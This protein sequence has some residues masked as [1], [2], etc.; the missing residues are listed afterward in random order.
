LVEYF[1]LLVKHVHPDII[2]HPIS[3]KTSFSDS[4]LHTTIKNCLSKKATFFDPEKGSCFLQFL[5]GGFIEE[6]KCTVLDYVYTRCH[7]Y[8]HDLSPYYA[9]LKELNWSLINFLRKYGALTYEELM[10]LP[11][12]QNKNYGFKLPKDYHETGFIFKDEANQ[13]CYWVSPNLLD[14][15]K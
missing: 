3:R 6:E 15:A 9:D 14:N 4:Y 8:L 1:K 7:C 11:I 2:N 5:R 12:Q 13:T 10:I